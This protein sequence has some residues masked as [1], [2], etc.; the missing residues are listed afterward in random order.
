M[1]DFVDEALAITHFV[2]P[3]LPRSRWFGAVLCIVSDQSTEWS[4]EFIHRD[5]ETA[6]QCGE[7]P[8]VPQ[9]SLGKP[10]GLT[11]GKPSYYVLSV[12]IDQWPKQYTV[13]C[14]LQVYVK[15]AYILKSCHGNFIGKIFQQYTN[16]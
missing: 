2:L 5:W 14:D 16:N 6:G 1:T 15:R 13:N 4:C 10:A 11:P 12:I 9:H 7:G 8:A 3:F